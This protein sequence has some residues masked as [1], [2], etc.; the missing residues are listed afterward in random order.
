MHISGSG[1]DHSA[2]VESF[3]RRS[4][5][6]LFTFALFLRVSPLSTS[7]LGGVLR[8]HVPRVRRLLVTASNYR[9]LSSHL[10]DL[11]SL[12]LTSL[13]YHEAVVISNY[14]PGSF[15]TMSVPPK[16]KNEKNFFRMIELAQSTLQHLNLYFQ[17]RQ[18]TV[19]ATHWQLTDGPRHSPDRD[20]PLGVARPL[21][22]AAAARYRPAPPPLRAL[23]RLAAPRLLTAL[24]L[25]NLGSW[26][27]TPLSLEV[28][29]LGVGPSLRAF[30]LSGCGLSF[31]EML[32]S[33][34]LSG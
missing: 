34:R 6:H 32:C 14:V 1:K 8:Q 19:T 28:L 25:V 33:P 21:P 10:A 11:S 7:R 22:I 17:S 27:A 29:L 13:E 20:T 23:P 5:D 31:P 16:L 4:Q 18:D 15:S 30:H 24:R 26:A 12:S 2:T 9:S 3:I